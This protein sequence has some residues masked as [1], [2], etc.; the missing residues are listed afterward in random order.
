MY[1]KYRKSTANITH[2]KLEALDTVL[3]CG[4]DPVSSFISKVESVFVVPSL[5]SKQRFHKL[6]THSERVAAGLPGGQ[7]AVLVRVDTV[8]KHTGNLRVLA[9]IVC[10]PPG[11]PDAGVLHRAADPRMGARG[12]RGGGRCGRAEAE[13]GRARPATK[14]PRQHAASLARVLRRPPTLGLPTHTAAAICRRFPGPPSKEIFCSEMV[15]KLY[16]QLDVAGFS[17]DRPPENSKRLEY[18]EFTPLHLEVA[19]ALSGGAAGGSVVYAKLRGRILLDLEEDDS[20]RKVVIIDSDFQE[21]SFPFLKI[22][23]DNWHPVRNNKLSPFAVPFGYTVDGTP[24]FISRCQIGETL[25]IGYT[26]AKGIM[27]ANWEGLEL[28]IEYDHEVLILADSSEYEWVQ[29]G[30]LLMGAVPRQAISGGCDAYGNQHYIARTRLMD[31]GSLGLGALVIGRVAPSLGGARFTHAGKEVSKYGDYEVLCKRT[32]FL[33]RVFFGLGAEHYLV[34]VVLNE[35]T[36]KLGVHLNE[37]AGFSDVWGLDSES[38][39]FVTRPVRAVLLLFPASSETNN[40]GTNI[41]TVVPIVENA[42][43]AAASAPFFIKQTIANAC[44]TIALLH[45][46]GNNTTHFPASSPSPLARL[47]TTL[48]PLNP[49]ARAHAL[50]TAD[51]LEAIHTAVATS[52]LAQTDTPDAHDDVDLHF[53][54]FVARAGQ[55]WEL[56]GRKDGPVSHGV[57]ADDDDGGDAFLAKTVEVVKQFIARDPDGNNFTVL[58]FGGQ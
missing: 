4:N 25:Q 51:D 28:P 41:G 13:P 1:K 34:F 46:L 15:A 48:A 55:L 36:A 37:G 52:Q 45:A 6:W 3:F 40:T 58:A 23:N 16:G 7:Q 53:V 27:T 47:L 5:G 17:E 19:D 49:L 18:D 11:K 9:D 30:K 22:T 38:L 2:R 20:G 29:S 14:R 31:P 56:D 8:R 24:T 26:T 32:H 42:A 44:G 54:A 35:Y 21:Q 50:E 33:D 10:G 43:A 57:I 39:S 12:G